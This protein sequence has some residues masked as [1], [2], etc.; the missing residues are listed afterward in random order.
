MSNT[1]AI[2][3]VTAALQ[4][5][6]LSG[7]NVNFPGATVTIGEPLPPS[8]TKN[9]QVNICMYQI[10]PNMGYRNKDLP[11]KDAKGNWITQPMLGLDLHYLLSF[12]GN[13]Q[14]LEPERLLG[15]VILTLYTNPILTKSLIETT[16]NQPL[17]IFLKDSDLATANIEQVKFIPQAN[18]QEKIAELW[19]DYYSTIPYALSLAYQASVVVI[20]ATESLKPSTPVKTVV[21]DTFP[22]SCS[23]AE[24][25]MHYGVSSP[26]PKKNR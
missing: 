24:A 3:T 5:L 17:Y 2:A 13:Q 22:I 9:P 19:R 20:N 11:A 23:A 25:E 7:I 21:L 18:P 15:D 6:L 4:Q 16:I 1:L 14:K 8:P 10:S 26:V 12:Y